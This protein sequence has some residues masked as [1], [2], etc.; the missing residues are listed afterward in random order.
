MVERKNALNKYPFKA[1]I[2][3]EFRYY[4]QYNKKVVR[5]F[6]LKDTFTASFSLGRKRYS[7]K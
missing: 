4:F 6:Y 1:K 2:F 5:L 7:T 3:S